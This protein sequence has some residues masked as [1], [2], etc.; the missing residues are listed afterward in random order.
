MKGII[1]YTDNRLREPIFSS[2]QKQL[3][4]ANLPIVSVS[5]APIDFG[6]NFVLDL[7]PSYPTMVKQIVKALEESRADYVFFCEHDVL[8]P[9]SHFDFT[10]PQDDIFYYNT[11]VWRWDYPNNRAITYDGLI[12]LS[13]LCVRRTLALSHFQKR[14]KAIQ[15][16]EGTQDTRPNPRFARVWGYEPGTKKISQGGFSDDDFDTWRSTDPIIDVRH[17]KTFSL[18][19]VSFGA[20]VNLPKNWRETTLDNLPGW[21]VY[22]NNSGLQLFRQ[23]NV[24]K[25]I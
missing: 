23:K 18:R 5:L 11:H 15:E 14:L 4:R 10:P 9:V 22:P 2:V 12:S 17:D 7:T 25:P 8:Y 21:D 6:K 13:S 24:V 1:Y 16:T 20:F 19:K 3:L